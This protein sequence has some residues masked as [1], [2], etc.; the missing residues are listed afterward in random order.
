[1]THPLTARAS[2]VARFHPAYRHTTDALNNC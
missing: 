2:V 1:M